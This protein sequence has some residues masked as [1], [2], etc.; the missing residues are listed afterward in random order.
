MSF[1]NQLCNKNKQHVV[2]Y[3]FLQADNAFSH[4][5]VQLTV[6]SER[7]IPSCNQVNDNARQRA[8]KSSK[9]I[10]K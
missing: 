3:S 8:W 10:G 7:H 9:L 1:N 6:M 4:R 2:M 5:T